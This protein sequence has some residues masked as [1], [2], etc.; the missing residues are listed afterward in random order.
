MAYFPIDGA[1]KEIVQRMMAGEVVE[2]VPEGLD[3]CFN[4]YSPRSGRT[5]C[6]V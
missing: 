3:Y 6:G 2:D 4:Q 5:H 1:N